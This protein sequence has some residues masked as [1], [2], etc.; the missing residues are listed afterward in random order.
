MEMTN[1]EIYTDSFNEEYKN[2][3]S[4]R[5]MLRTAVVQDTHS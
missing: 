4:L 2:L 3:Y 5:N 1:S